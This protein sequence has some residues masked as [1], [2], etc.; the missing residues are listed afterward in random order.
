[1][2]MMI[3]PGQC[4]G[5]T[6]LAVSLVFGCGGSHKSRN[7]GP[8]GA[9]GAAGQ[10]ATDTIPGSGGTTGDGSVSVVA[11]GGATA[12]SPGG[13]A[14]GG[15]GTAT[16]GS[17][18][19]GTS[20]A[21]TGGTTDSGSCPNLGGPKMVKLAAGFC[22]DSTEVTRAQYAAWVSGN[23]PTNGQIAACA[24]NT[25][26]VPDA[27][28]MGLPTDPH[29]VCLE[30][31]DEHP[32]VCIDWCDAYAYCQAVGKRLCGKIGGGPNSTSDF[33]DPERSQWYSACTSNGAN[34]YPYGATEDPKACNGNDHWP[35]TSP[36]YKYQTLPVGSLAT[37]QSSVAGYAGV[38]DLSG[39]VEEF[40]D[41]CDTEDRYGDRCNIR[42]GSFASSPSHLPCESEVTWPRNGYANDIG[43][44]CC[45]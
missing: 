29:Y 42:G 7:T 15:K 1:M 24:T 19:T 17:G 5:M 6:G 11:S 3:R 21:G 33:A 38:F 27:K 44:R 4:L 28:C 39:S 10:T 43:F 9:A 45:L 37:C 23:P 25:T 13:S 18:G 30:N 8:D 41:S 14:T 34:K 2:K 35:Q 22:I 40:E 36:P 31:C 26:F 12:S 20:S 32:Q 16:G